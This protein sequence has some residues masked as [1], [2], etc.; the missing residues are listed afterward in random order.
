MFVHH[1]FFWLKEADN[2]EARATLARELHQ[3]KAIPQIEQHH[4]GTAAETRRPAIDHSY[5]FSLLLFFKDKAA[6]DAYQVHPIH[7][8]FVQNCGKLWSKVRVYDSEA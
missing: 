6:H 2:D 1:V 8:A 3:L 7:E 5:D 4:V